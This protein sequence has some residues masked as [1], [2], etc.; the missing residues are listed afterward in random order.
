MLPA[1]HVV[2]L[3]LRWH[4]GA[5][6][7]ALH[8]RPNAPYEGALALPGVLLLAGERLDDA[9]RRALGKVGLPSAGRAQVRQFGAFDDSNRDLR[10]A[11]IAIA[12]FVLGAA[13]ATAP[14]AVWVSVTDVPALA[15]GHAVIVAEAVVEARRLLWTDLW[16]TSGILPDG[17]AMNELLSL[18]RQLVAEFPGAQAMIGR[19]IEMHFADRAG[20]VGRSAKWVWRTSA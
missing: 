11:T 20:Y 18:S 10:G 15:F 1:V 7:L 5:L 17:F 12:H 8:R 13:A 9:A 4:D 16:F 2:V 14:D 6:H 19:W 3:T